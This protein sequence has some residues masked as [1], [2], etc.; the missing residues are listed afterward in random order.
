MIP[1]I[2]HVLYIAYTFKTRIIRF[3]YAK[4]E[5]SFGLCA[6]GGLTLM[7]RHSDNTFIFLWEY[8]W[9]NKN[10]HLKSFCH[11]EF[12]RICHYFFCLCSKSWKNCDFQLKILWNKS[13]S[14]WK[15]LQN[16]SFLLLNENIFKLQKFWKLVNKW[17]RN[18]WFLKNT[19]F[20][21]NLPNQ[22][23]TKMWWRRTKIN[24]KTKPCKKCVPRG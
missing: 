6:L 2:F 13:G 17:R 15:S 19:K 18:G 16:K 24:S 4:R 21:Q 22:C 14:K 11:A 23:A 1:I 7:E 3:R 10:W 5:C 8:R 20:E 12:L 9:G